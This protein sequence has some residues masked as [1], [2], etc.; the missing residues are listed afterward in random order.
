MR[1][2]ASK[3][4]R[5]VKRERAKFC[6]RMSLREYMKATEANRVL[7]EERKRRNEEY[8]N[9][10]LLSEALER[11]AE[12]VAHQPTPQRAGET[13]SLPTEPEPSHKGN[14]REC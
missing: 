7:E 12:D 6:P 3:D 10:V 4:R 11:D 2:Q 14:E 13:E 8:A 9:E 1:S 5:A